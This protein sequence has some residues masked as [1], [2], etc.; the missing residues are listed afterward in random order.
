MIS[1]VFFLYIDFYAI[2]ALQRSITI[3]FYD[4]VLPLNV[5]S[6]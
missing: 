5:I 2:N 4:P 1:H 6:V 3:W